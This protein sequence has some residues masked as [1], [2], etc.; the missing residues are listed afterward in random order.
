[1]SLHDKDIFLETEAL[2]PL[3]VTLD[4]NAGFRT[5]DGYFNTLQETIEEQALPR[6]FDEALLSPNSKSTYFAA[7]ESNI[8]AQAAAE[9]ITHLNTTR[10][11]HRA[12]IVRFATFATGIAAT[13]AVLW[14]IDA[15]QQTPC[16]SFECMLSSYTISEADLRNLEVEAWETDL[17]DKKASL[18]T[19]LDD[20]VLTAYILEDND[21]EWMLSELMND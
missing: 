11:I 19:H 13:I 14:F 21:N 3:L 12:R 7:L 20:E 17:E 5:P 9:G 6:A 4:R 18:F 8:L 15:N 10:S 16:N 1:M 2:A